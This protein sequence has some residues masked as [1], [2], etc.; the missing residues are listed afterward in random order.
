MRSHSSSA[1]PTARSRARAISEFDDAPVEEPPGPSGMFA[2][3]G[4]VLLIALG[5]GLAAQLL[6]GAPH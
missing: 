3:L 2:R 1:A 5:F 6:V 4:V